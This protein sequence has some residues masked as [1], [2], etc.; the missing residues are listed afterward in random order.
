MAAREALEFPVD[1]QLKALPLPD[2]YQNLSTDRSLL[3][4]GSLMH[5]LAQGMF[6][7]MCSFWNAP[8]FMLTSKST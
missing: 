3:K 6:E 7:L 8:G 1:W 4:T 2:H 5:G